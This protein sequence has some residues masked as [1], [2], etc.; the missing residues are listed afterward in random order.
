M[1]TA[2]VRSGQFI[3]QYA[4]SDP[5][6]AS[7]FDNNRVFISHKVAEV[8]IQESGANTHTRSESLLCWEDPDETLCPQDDTDPGPGVEYRSPTLV[9]L[10]NIMAT[11]GVTVGAPL[12]L[13]REREIYL[14]F[15]HEYRTKKLVT[16]SIA[17]MDVEGLNNTQKR[18][19]LKYIYFGNGVDITTAQSLA[20]N[21]ITNGVIATYM[22]YNLAT[23]PLHD[24]R[25]LKLFGEVGW[26]E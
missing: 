14:A 12:S 26:F 17:E 1:A 18:R 8:V 24:R 4:I 21:H 5:G 10:D 22:D 19:A 6:N 25:L 13:P 23:I 15:W 2:V 3:D 7:G 9:F 20:N 16:D 11:G